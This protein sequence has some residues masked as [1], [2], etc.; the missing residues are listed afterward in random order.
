MAKNTGEILVDVLCDWGVDTIFGLPGDGINGFLE[1]LRKNQDRIRFVQ[2]RHEESAAF[3][4][5][6]WAK[7]TGRLGVCLATS[8][9]G[10]IHLLNGLYDAKLDGQPVLAITGNQFH[11]LTETYGQQDVRLERLFDDVAL[12]N[13]KCMGPEHMENIAHLACRSALE[14]RAV[15]HITMPSDIQSKELKHREESMRNIPHHMSGT[16]GKYT[17]I[18]DNAE[19]TRATEVINEGKKVAFLIGSGARGA[20]EEVLALAER[21]GA[22]IAKALLGKDVLSDL[23]PQVTGTLGL[24][25]TKPSQEAM[26]D[27]DTLV[28]IGTSF[29]YIEFLPRPGQARCVQIDLDPQRIGLRCPVDVALVGDARSTLQALLPLVEEKP[30][31]AFGLAIGQKT[32]AWW[33]DMEERGTSRDMPMKPQVVA[34]EMGRRL[35]DDAIVCCDAGTVATWYARQMPVRDGQRYSLSG[36]LATMACGLPYGIAAQT[37]YPDRQ[38]VVFIG[39][40]AFTMLLGELATCVK[41]DLP[42]KIVVIKNDTLGMIK[43]EQIAMEGNPE[44]GCELQTIDFVSVARGFGA[45]AM[46]IE[47]PEKCG[48]QLTE[49]FAM[50]G[51]VVIEAV[52]DPFTPPLPPKISWEQAKNFALALA[53]GEPHPFRIALT[54]GWDKVRELT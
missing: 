38:V 34:W 33:K 40:G 29:P 26:E 23:H 53:K 9:P 5:C 46:R 8:G 2:V 49:A 31:K 6:A 43:W 36:N 20:R 42:I 24:L 15:A 19:L 27:C 16:R 51:P 17:V 47:D 3:M 50:N 32:V 10:G 21:I 4:A 52:I 41:Y 22:P 14:Y 12:Y 35:A 44:F 45:R 37:A 30:D 48:D 11:D 7:F 28:M 25:G 54:A 13:V 18:P 39:D 1:V